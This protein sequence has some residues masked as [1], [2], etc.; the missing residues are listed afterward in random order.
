MA[1]SEKFNMFGA[2]AYLNGA[3][4]VH[5]KLL[6]QRQ[7]P[8]LHDL[9]RR[10]RNDIRSFVILRDEQTLEVLYIYPPYFNNQRFVSKLHCSVSR[11]D[12]RIFCH[13]LVALNYHKLHLFEQSEEAF[14]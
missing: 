7:Q 2:T 1:A 14:L 12:I 5:R 4:T 3:Q 13:H 8:K 9:S 11:N 10:S 6:R